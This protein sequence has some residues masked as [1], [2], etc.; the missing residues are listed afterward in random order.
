LSQQ[1][2][3]R[4]DIR[5]LWEAKCAACHG[6]GSPYL[7]DFEENKAKYQAMSKGTRMDTYADLLFFIAWPDAGAMMRRLDDGKNTK[8]GKPGNMYLYLGAGDKE[9]QENLNRFKA[10]IGKGAWNLKRREAITSEELR[11]IEARY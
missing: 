5:P 9:R 7:G 11:R 10:W 8:D 6:A 3:Y 2:T 4:K 1:L